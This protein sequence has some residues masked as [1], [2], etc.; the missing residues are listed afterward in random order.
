MN[1]RCYDDG[2][3]NGN[4]FWPWTKVS[5]DSHFTVVSGNCFAH[6][7]LS[8]AILAFW[9]AKSLK[10]LCAVWVSVGI[11]MSHINFTVVMFE[12]NSECQGIIKT[13]TFLLQRILEIADI[14]SISV[15]SIARSIIGFGLFLWIEQRFHSLIVWTLWFDQVHNVEFVSSKLFDVLNLEIKPLGEGSR[16]MIIFKD[17]VVFVVTNFNSST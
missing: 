13:A 17:Q 4:F 7:S 2:S 14:L 8:D 16:V 9:L 12:L 1:P 15:P 6:D 5:D 3:S 11:A 10:E